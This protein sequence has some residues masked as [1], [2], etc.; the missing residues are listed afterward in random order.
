M[1]GN[2]V[3]T[4]LYLFFFAVVGQQLK[5][6]CTIASGPISCLSYTDNSMCLSR[7]DL[8]LSMVTFRKSVYVHH[9]SM[10]PNAAPGLEISCHARY[11][12]SSICMCLCLCSSPFPITSPPLLLL[13]SFP[14]MS[15]CEGYFHISSWFNLSKSARHIVHGH[16]GGTGWV[17]GGG[18]HC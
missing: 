18:I 7:S 13:P 16:S 4:V 9:L 3:N 12:P 10:Y 15:S 5:S 1:H 14:P 6:L 2:M 8:L 17:G 11:I